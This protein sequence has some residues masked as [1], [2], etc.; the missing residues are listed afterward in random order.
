MSTM[1]APRCRT[2]AVEQ[3]LTAYEARSQESFAAL[4]EDEQQE[5]DSLYLRRRSF[6]RLLQFGILVFEE[7]EDVNAAWRL[8]VFRASQEY[9]KKD[10]DF[11]R[12]LFER[13]LRVCEQD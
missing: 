9:S 10:D 6:E 2:A 3:E 11:F 12:G 5:S 1:Q 7:L 13:W 8:N 4:Q